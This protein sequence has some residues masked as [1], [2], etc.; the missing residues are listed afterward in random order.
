MAPD[1]QDRADGPASTPV[2]LGPGLLGLGLA[3]PVRPAASESTLT[4]LIA[5]GANLLV[6]VAKSIAAVI[7]GSASLAAETAHSWADT[8]NEIFLVVANPR[9]TRPPDQAHPLG[10]GREAYV[11]SLFAAL[12]LFVAGGAVSIIHGVSELGAPTPAGDFVVGYVVLA[13]SFVLEG[14]SLLRSI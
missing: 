4:V 1:D 12:G 14:T 9:S 11:W 7:T 8:G 13:L 3:W 6:A 5:L 10:H 2:G